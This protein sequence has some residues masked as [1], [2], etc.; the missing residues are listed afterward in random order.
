[1]PAI[2]LLPLALAVGAGAFVVRDVVA[3]TGL[4]SQRARAPLSALVLQQQ[5]TRRGNST[6]SARSGGTPSTTS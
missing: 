2:A 3:P 4:D 6:T 1:V 5:A